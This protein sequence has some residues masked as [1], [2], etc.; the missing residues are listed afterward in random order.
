MK[1]IL[2]LTFLILSSITNVSAF[3]DIENNWY[4]QSIIALKEQGAI[5]GYDENTFWPR[6]NISRAE[7]LKVVFNVSKIEVKTPVEKCFKDVALD[8]WQASY[9]CSGFEKGI[10]K[11]YNNWNFKPN[12]NVSVLEVLAFA[13][14]IFNIDL[15]NYETW[16]EWYEAYQKFADVNKIIPIHSYK[17]TDLANRWLSSSIIYRMSEYSKN[18]KLDYKSL[19]CEWNSVLKSWEFSITINWNKRDYLLYVPNWTTSNTEKSLIVAFHGRTNSNEMVRDYMQ[20]GWWKYWA[21]NKQ[22]DFIVAYPSGMWEWPYSWY[23]YENIEFFDA[24]VSEI[25]EKSCINRDSVFTVWHSLGSWMSNKTS[26]LR[27]DIVRGMV[28]VASAGYNK[29]CVWAVSSLILHLEWDPLSSY[30]TWLTAFSSKWQNNLCSNEYENTTLW[31]IKSCQSKNSCSEGNSVTFCNSY[32][33]YWSDQHSWPKDW[34]W[35]ILK[36]LK[37]L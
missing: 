17:I 9:I 21:N 23:D 4:K 20:I 6:N 28:W 25:S 15:K 22:S 11:G 5:N 37:S 32:S 3:S 1:K 33:T 18:K 29:N 31:N 34:S 19:G 2:I 16:W 13:V 10:A 24:I 7:I 14:R 8:W 35:D 36:F 26:C 12:G 27:W 30:S